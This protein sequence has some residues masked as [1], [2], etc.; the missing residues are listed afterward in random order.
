MDQLAARLDQR[1]RLL[2]GGSRAALP[3]QQ[4]LRATLDWSY[5]LLSEPERRLFNR[6]SVFAGGWTLEA[7]EAVCA[8]DGIEP[9]DVL[10]LLLR[11]VR[12]SLVVAEEGRRWCRA[13]SAAG[14]APPVRPRAADGSRGSRNGSRTTRELLPRRWWKRSEPSMWEQAWLD[15][16]LTEH[17]N[18]RAAMRWLSESNAVEQAVRLGGRLWPMWV[19]GGFLTEGRAQLAHPA[20]APS[21]VACV[22]RTGRG[23]SAPMVL[24]SCSREITLPPAPG[25]RRPSHSDGTRRPAPCYDARYL[26]SRRVNRRTMRR[27]ARGWTRAWHWLRRSRGSNTASC[28]TLDCLGTVA[29][30]LGDYDLARSGTSKA[31]RS[32]ESGQS[33]RAGRGR[34]ITWAA[35][36]STRA[37]MQRHG[38]GWRR[39]SSCVRRIR[40]SSGS[41]TCW[42][43]SRPWQRPRGCQRQR[44]ASGGRHR[45]LT[46]QDRHPCP[47][48]RARTV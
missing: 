44:A 31:W 18:L 36:H 23:W 8:G 9:E 16:L 30:A 39:V 37:T 6:L 19:R 46:Q 13:V 14:D 4:T 2:T 41:S 17:D 22:R 32:R 27:P 45:R 28:K 29:H 40:Q 7:A 21:G 25:S 11:L 20:G 24:S 12:K 10:D 43:S 42:P 1:F 38:R 48:Q 15:R 47:T 3:R 35:W 33:V 5:D 34:S 26:G